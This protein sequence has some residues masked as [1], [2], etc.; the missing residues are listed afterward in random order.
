[1]KYSNRS[2]N[3][4]SNCAVLQGNARGANLAVDVVAAHTAVLPGGMYDIWCTVDVHIKIA[5]TAND[6]TTLTGYLL[7][8]NTGTND[9]KLRTL[10]TDDIYRI[11]AIAGA[12][13]VLSFHLVH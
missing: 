6:V 11:G 5:V 13:G 7:R 8:A 12:A 4:D 1:M 2:V 10:L 9:N 3:L